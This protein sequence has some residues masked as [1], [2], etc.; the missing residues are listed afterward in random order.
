[1]NQTKWDVSNMLMLVITVFAVLLQLFPPKTQ[2]DQFKSAVYFFGIIG[3]VLLMYTV[4]LALRKVKGYLNQI[5]NNTQELN[6][7]KEKLKE[8]KRMN[9]FDKR[10]SILEVLLRSK[11]GKFEFD[12]MWLFMA[13]LLALFYLYLRSLGLVP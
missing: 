4:H 6:V 5:E 12:P 9:E 1:M 11:A 2:I 8:E 3:Y 7:F 10:L 13:L